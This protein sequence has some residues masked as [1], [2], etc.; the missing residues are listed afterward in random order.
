MLS[1]A[2]MGRM[3]R[4]LEEALELEPAGRRRWLEALAAEHQDLEP[5][6]RRALLSDGT[7]GAED[8]LFFA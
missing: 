3:S 7:D 4:L 2:Q 8:R 5:A 1:A 6:L